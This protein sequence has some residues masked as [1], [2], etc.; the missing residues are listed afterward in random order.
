MRVA[1]LATGV[2]ELHGLA[3]CLGQLFPSHS[4]EIVAERRGSVGVPAQ[5]F[6]QSFTS[7]IDLIRP[8]RT[9]TTL[10]KLVRKLAAT[11]YPRT[12]GAPDVALVVDD[13]ELCNVDQPGV[14]VEAVRRAVEAHLA[15][16]PLLDVERDELRAALR[17]R[18]SYHLAVPMTES[19]FYGDPQS[20]SRN[21][22]PEGRPVLL[23]AG[24][25]PEQLQTDDPAYSADDGSAC[26]QL[27]DRNR[28]RREDRRPPW[29]LAPQPGMPWVDPEENWCTA[30]QE[31]KAGA[32]ALRALDWGA[33]LANPA[34]CAYARALID[35]LAAALL[36]PPPFPQGGAI[37]PL[38]A[39]KPRALAAVLRN[40]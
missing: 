28:R 31:S 37:A 38:T 6:N 26:A 19:W 40:L 23:Q 14:A 5:P 35:D 4:F 33:V 27:L 15:N 20:S 9:P 16:T 10:E 17:E 3:A 21:G 39:Y 7:R 30:W 32:E 24:V 34:H 12:R 13:L 2:M 18:A 25:D 36:E 22:V 1:V 29:V 11:V 8:L